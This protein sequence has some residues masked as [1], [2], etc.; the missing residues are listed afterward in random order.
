MWSATRTVPKT[1]G[2]ISMVKEAQAALIHSLL[3]KEIDSVELE[4][5]RIQ[6][7]ISSEFKS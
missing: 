5:R 2:V 4:K 1:I 6:A 3:H 7:G